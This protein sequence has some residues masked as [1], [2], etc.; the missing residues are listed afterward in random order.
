MKHHGG[1]GS[2]LRA[3]L[4]AMDAPTKQQSELTR[5]CQGEGTPRILPI[6]R[7]CGF[8]TLAAAPGAGKT[9]FAGSA[10]LQLVNT[11]DVGRLVRFVPT[12][13]LRCQVR[14]ELAVVGV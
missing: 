13:N 1:I 7:R 9:L 14:N 5:E 2:V 11:G 8:A 4:D 12:R 6:L 3:P 10:V